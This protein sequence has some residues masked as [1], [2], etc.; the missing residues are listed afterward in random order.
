MGFFSADRRLDAFVQVKM[1]AA[2]T[3]VM[4]DIVDTLP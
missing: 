3:K 2:A 1:H 4:T